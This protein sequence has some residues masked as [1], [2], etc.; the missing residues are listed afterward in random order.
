MGTWASG[1]LDNDTSRDGIGDVVYALLDALEDAVVSE[2]VGRISG[3]LGVIAQLSPYDL[4]DESAE[5]PRVRNAARTALIGA[6]PG[7][8]DV[9]AAIAG[10]DP[11][12]GGEVLAP[13]LVALLSEGGKSPF[14]ARFPELFDSAEA[15]RVVQG[16]VDQM[17]AAIAQDF[18]DDYVHTDLCREGM[19]MGQLGALLVLAPAKLP[20]AT[21]EAWRE[22]ARQ[23][24]AAIQANE[25]GEVEFHRGYYANVDAV[26]A[27]LIARSS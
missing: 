27:E 24:F 19:A 3:T 8:R 4:S 15:R 20:K 13:N 6:R 16:I 23:G 12:P 25:D 17:V 18:D 14:G 5:T 9:L 21:L 22:R 1:L 10:G 7:V 26:L 11:V 2:N